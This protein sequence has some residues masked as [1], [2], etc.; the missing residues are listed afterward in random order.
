MTIFYSF[1]AE[2]LIQIS[3]SMHARQAFHTLATYTVVSSREITL[4]LHVIFSFAV[5][6]TIAI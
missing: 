6:N 5:A 3:E 2:F 4:K 1:D